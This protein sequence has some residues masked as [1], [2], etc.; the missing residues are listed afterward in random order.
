MN[1]PSLQKIYYKSGQSNYVSLN[2]VSNVS[3]TKTTSFGDNFVLGGV[4]SAYSINAPQQVE[5]NFDRSFIKKDDLFKYT[6]SDPLAKIYVFNSSKYYEINNLYLTQYSVNFTVGDIPKINTKFTSYGETIGQDSQVPGYSIIDV[7]DDIDIP[8]LNSI[9]ITGESS[10]EIKNIYNISSIDYSMQFN[11]QP[12]YNIGY[13]LPSEV[14]SILPIK[15]NL[16]II[17]KL[18]NESSKIAISNMIQSGLNFDIAISGAIQTVNFPIRK[19]QLLSTEIL[20]SS[21][22]TLDV[23]HNFLGV[24]GI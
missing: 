6:G 22:N 12:F 5:V 15:I 17:S 1:D 10:S 7:N 13:D 9:L 16:S 11:R 20:L 24:Y 3:I 14:Y 23:K 2:D 4:E 19:A 8:R 18:K 21:Q